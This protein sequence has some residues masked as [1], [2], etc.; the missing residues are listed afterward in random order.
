MQVAA[1]HGIAS[2]QEAGEGQDELELW[3]A[4]READELTV[5]CAP[6]L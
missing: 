1:E 6:G 2:V 3:D 4:L 5:S